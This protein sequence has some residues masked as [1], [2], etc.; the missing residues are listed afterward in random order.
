[1]EEEQI[2]IYKYCCEQCEYKCKHESE[3]LKHC[4]TEKHKTGIRKK[5][6]DCKEPFK[7]DKCEY[8]T[9]NNTTFKLHKLNEHG[10]LEERAVGFKFYCKICD[11]GTF[12]TDI[13]NNH[14]NSDKHKKYSIRNNL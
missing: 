2:N 11:F 14:N 13:F 9:K 1:M 3:W 8:K 12:S 10:S 4:N 6:S 5:R 7:C